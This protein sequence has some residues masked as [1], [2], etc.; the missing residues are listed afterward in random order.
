MLWTSIAALVAAGVLYFAFRH[1]DLERLSDIILGAEP[2]WLL[3]LAISI[4]IEQVLRG[5]KWRQ[6]LYDIR[7]VGTL[8]LFSAV[9]VGYFANMIIPIGLS[10]LVRAW[11]IARLE[12]LKIT[13]VLLTTA[14]ERFVDGIVFAVLVGI[15]VSF[16][17]LPVTEGN[18]RLG[19]M[20]A[21]ISSLVLFIGLIGGLFLVKNHLIDSNSV[22]GR[23]VAWLETLFGGR[24]AGIGLGMA[25]GII[26]PKSRWRGAGIMLAGIAMKMISTSHFLWVGLVFGILLS[27]F[28][29]LFI[30]VVTG[31][32]LIVSR[33]IR[34]P[35]G[36]I[37]GSAFALKL[38]G[39]ADEEALT[40]VLVVHFS[41]MA[42][43]A[44]IGAIAMW[45]SGL[46][47]LELRRATRES[48]N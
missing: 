17:T 40:M 43:V 27:P 41:V 10:P 46:T 24:L 23:F 22:V 31:F 1:L 20:V 45:K 34:V 5:W 39:I 42:L 3:A 6:I 4:P 33:F 12:S 47:V 38:L 37:M 16:A 44:G 26:W 8:R 21:G 29:Y 36:G 13:T 30:M 7:P 32:G 14:I 19:L 18:L 2:L 35:G 28:D 15:L 11:L 25:E 48:L 9:M